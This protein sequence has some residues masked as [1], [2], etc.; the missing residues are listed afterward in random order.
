MPCRSFICPSPSSEFQVNQRSLTILALSLRNACETNLT[1]SE[2][3]TRNET[4][5]ASHCFKPQ[6]TNR[7]WHQKQSL[8]CNY[9]TANSAGPFA[10][11]VEILSGD[12]ALYPTNGHDKL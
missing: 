1:T 5:I 11:P 3:Y 7:T 4:G 12:H 6:V 2:P 9:V 10:G 8:A